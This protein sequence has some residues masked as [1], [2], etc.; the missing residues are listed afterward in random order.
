MQSSSPFLRKWGPPALAVSITIGLRLALAW[1]FGAEVADLSNY[2]QA[3]DIVLR[4]DNIYYAPTVYPYTPVS[5]FVP[6]WSMQ[7]ARLL[8]L[9]FHFVVKWPTI[10]ADAGVVA[11]L[12]WLAVRRGQARQALLWGLAYGLNPI[13][14]LITA[15][16]GNMMGQ[17]VFFFF[18]AYALATI[19]DDDRYYRLSAL[20]LGIAIGLRGYPVLFVP[21]FLSKMSL[22]WRQRFVYVALAAMPAALTLLP[23]L[24]IS[25]N[26][27][28]STV[29]GYGGVGD[30]GWLAI[31]RAWWYLQTSSIWLPGSLGQE[32]LQYSKTIFMVLYGGLVLLGWRRPL[33][34]SLAGWLMAI[35]L[36]FYAI[37]GGVSSQYF[38]W[39]LPFAVVSL[40]R[41]TWPFTLTATLSILSFYLFFFPQI[42]WGS[43]PAPWKYS[44]AQMMSIH[45]ACLVVL[46]LVCLGWLFTSL[47]R[48]SHERSAAATTGGLP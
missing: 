9:P 3:A 42:L 29:L 25:G 1:V 26:A 6:A 47:W 18:W 46:W 27:V 15:F 16:H 5:L 10:L 34:A 8:S 12:Y 17:T 31:A 20:S 38:T 35:I 32:W 4:G 28:V 21:F 23:Y 19:G 33:R 22:N 41:W 43:F 45:L 37:Y 24:A 11:V 44:Q 39:I 48:P 36:L 7:L 2:H 30:H 40:S 14:I 13:T